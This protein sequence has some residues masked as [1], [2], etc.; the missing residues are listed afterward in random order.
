MDEDLIAHLRARI[1]QLRKVM[2]L[3]HDPRMIAILQEVIDSAEH[4]LRRLETDRD[5]AAAE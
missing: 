4:D 3:A 2:S 5:A 1:Q